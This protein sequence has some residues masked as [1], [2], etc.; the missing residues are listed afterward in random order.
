MAWGRS[1]ACVRWSA[2]LLSLS[3]GRFA[4][5]AAVAAAAEPARGE[6]GL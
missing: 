1:L 5:A 4:A 3:R 6:L 2:T